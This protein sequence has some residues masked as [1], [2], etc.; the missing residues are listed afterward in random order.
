MNTRPYLKW[1]PV[2]GMFLF[3]MGLAPRAGAA[4]PERPIRLVI[5]VPPGGAADFIGRLFAEKLGQELGQTVIAE[6]KVGASGMI[7]SQEVARAAPDGYTILLSSSTTHGTAPLVVRNPLYDPQTDFTHI[8]LIATVPAVVTVTKSLP[9]K[10][11][12]ELIEYSNKH[13]GTLNYG[14]SGT[15]SPL[16]L[17]GE[18][19]K[20][21]TGA[22]LEHVPYKGA[23]PAVLD[24]V[25]GRIQ[26]MFDGV[27]SQLGNIESGNTRALATM[28]DTRSTVLPDLPTMGEEGFPKVVGGLWFGI[29]G[30]KGMP[31]EAVERLSAALFKVT[32]MPEIQ[33]TY[34][35]RGVLTT[36]LKPSAYLDFIRSENE[37]YSKVVRHS[38]ITL[39]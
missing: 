2:F 12:A 16:H 7:A 25:A 6:N 13:K 28:N 38:N 27:P 11:I 19:F 30:P 34:A 32:G 37:K 5:P 14:S 9:V 10:S 21:I 3:F 36:P 20:S 22:S 24:L 26:V 39:D 1:A 23:G 8:G 18:L 35:E 33:K 17:W 15:G 4:Y 29:S 31:A